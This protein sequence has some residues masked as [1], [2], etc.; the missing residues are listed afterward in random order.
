MRKNDFQAAAWLA[1]ALRERLQWWLVSHCRN[2]PDS[3]RLEE[4]ARPMQQLIV[5]IVALV[6]PCGAE[7]TA[8]GSQ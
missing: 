3:R 7:T 6:H 4:R 8:L 5:L 1:P 2:E